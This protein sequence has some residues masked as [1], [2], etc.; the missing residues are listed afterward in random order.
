MTKRAKALVTE[1]VELLEECERERDHAQME[2]D[3]IARANDQLCDDI[4][5]AGERIRV[6]EEALECL[7]EPAFAMGDI[8]QRIARAALIGMSPNDPAVDRA[9]RARKGRAA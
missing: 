7:A 8:H 3:R 5:Q 1:L 4:T 2:A 9:W 6:L